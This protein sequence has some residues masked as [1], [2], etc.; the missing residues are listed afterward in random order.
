M[1]DTAPRRASEGDRDAPEGAA[2]PVSLDV[3]LVERARR[4][5]RA[6][7]GRLHTRFARMVHAILLGRVPRREADDLVQDV[8][9]DAL[10]KIDTL[11]EP[12][13]FGGWLAMIAR[14]RATDFL[15]ARRETAEL[16]EELAGGAGAGAGAALEASRAL[17]AIRALPEAYRETLL[18]RLVEGMSGPEI[19]A[20][21]GLKPDSVRV[22]LCRGL[23]MLREKLEVEK[24]P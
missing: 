1:S 11:R 3:A 2:G 24:G 5:D 22:N 9:V 23:A 15:R 18:M 14:N 16:P 17:A 4:G 21:S 6:A 13:A 10:G 20:Q 7:F 8:F 12:A 19:A